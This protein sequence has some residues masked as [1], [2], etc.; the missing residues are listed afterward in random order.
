SIAEKIRELRNYGSSKKYYNETIGYNMRLDELQASFLSVKL[1]YL[2]VFNSMRIEAANLYH[3]LLNDAGEIVLPF[4][5]SNCT[6]VYHLYV[7]RNKHRDALQEHLTKNGIGTM[8]HYPVPPHLQ[9]AYKDLGYSKGSFPVAEELA[10]T[11]LSLPL[12]PGITEDEITYTCNC[13]KDFFC[14]HY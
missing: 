8:I 13:V 6:H 4:V 2:E 11:S 12:F 10:D 5:A 9:K 14:S 1:K 7:I 3:E